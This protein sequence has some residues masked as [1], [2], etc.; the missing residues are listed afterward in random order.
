[1]VVS[2]QQLIFAGTPDRPSSHCATLTELPD[3]GLLAAWYSGTHEG[4][5]D[6]AIMA[7]RYE[8]GHWS[9]PWVVQDTPGL[10]DGN[11]L[12][13]TLPDGTVV[14]W[15]AV[16]EDRGWDSVRSYWRTSSDGG[17][18]WTTPELFVPRQGVMFRCRPVR[19]SSGRL[20]LPAYD[21]VT[22]EGL[23]FLSDDGGRT[24]REA[25]RMSAP[26]GCIQPA[27]VELTDSSL[28]SYLRTG[29]EGGHIWR[30]VSHDGGESWSAC[31]ATNLPN[32]NAGLDLLKLL[33]GRL[34]LAYN[35]VQRDRH[36]LAV[37]VSADAGDTWQDLLLED[38][39]GAEFSYPTLLQDRSGRCHLLYTFRRTGIK[40]V[41]VD[42]KAA[43]ARESV[44]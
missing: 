30:S 23:P 33:D 39:P 35:P 42:V 27:I 44:R 28:M 9:E 4:A 20:I 18:N 16:I 22:W 10:S 25:G 17:R 38:E 31:A 36:R 15:T 43:S 3:D 1:M 32:P 19:L 24:W 2:Q 21:E 8:G 37:A 41:I 26:T 13:Y 40:H 7:A 12:L 11:P 14:M 34:V 5:P 29:G 6:V